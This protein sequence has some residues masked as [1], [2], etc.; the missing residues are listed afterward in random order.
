MGGQNSFAYSAYGLRGGGVKQKNAYVILEYVLSKLS[1]SC[2]SFIPLYY[3]PKHSDSK[4]A[5]PLLAD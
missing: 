3:V 1:F 2:S 5:I 4:A